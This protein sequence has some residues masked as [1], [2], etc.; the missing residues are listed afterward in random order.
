MYSPLLSVSSQIRMLETTL[1]HRFP[2]CIPQL[3]F[4][5]LGVYIGSGD[6]QCQTLLRSLYS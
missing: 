4:L 6:G 2:N 5:V 3:K 1:V